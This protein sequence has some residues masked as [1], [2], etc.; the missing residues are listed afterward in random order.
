MEE[1]F[2]EFCGGVVGKDG[3]CSICDKDWEGFTLELRIKKRP[4]REVSKDYSDSSKP[5]VKR[6]KSLR[7]FPMS[8]FWYTKRRI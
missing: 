2:C 5:R 1:D 3:Y 7:N 4:D 6:G 8:G